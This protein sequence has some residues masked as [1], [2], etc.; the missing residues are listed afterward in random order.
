MHIQRVG[1]G[2]NLSPVILFLAAVL[3]LIPCAL[4]HGETTLKE[5]VVSFGSLPA[6]WRIYPASLKVS[7]DSSRVAWVAGRE[8]KFSVVV[9]SEG[10][11]PL[12]DGIGADTP[13]FSPDSRHIAYKAGKGAK[14]MLVVDS[15]EQ[16][17]YDGVSAPLFSPDSSHWACVAQKN[18]KQFV[19]LDG[20]EGG[21]YDGIL[22]KNSPLFS[23]N[24]AHVAYVVVKGRKMS[25]VEDGREG[26]L[27]DEVS[28]PAWS[29]DSSRLTYA[30]RKAGKWFMVVNGK[31]G[32]EYERIGPCAFSPDSSHSAYTARKDD[33][34]FM[35]VDG[36][37]GQKFDVVAV[38]IYSPD[39]NHLACLA[40]DDKKWSI[41]LDGRKGDGYDEI[42]FMVFSPDSS[43]VSCSVRDG[44]KWFMVVDGKKGPEYEVPPV[45]FYSPDSSRLVYIARKG[46]KMF[47]V[48]NGK[49]GVGYERITV[50]VFSP[51]SSHLAYMALKDGKWRV[52]ADGKEGLELDGVAVP[53][54]SP[55]SSHLAY[56]ALKDEEWMVVVDGKKGKTRFAGFLKGSSLVFDSPTHLHAQVFAAF[57]VGVWLLA[58]YFPM[59]DQP[60]EQV[61]LNVGVEG[62]PLV[63]KEVVRPLSEFKN[64]HLVKQAYDY[65]CGSAAL[66]TILNHY[67][68]EKFD[69][70]Q[71]IHGLLRY[72]DRK[73]IEER[74]AFSLLD[75]KKFVNVL[76]Y[77]GAGY[78]AEIDDLRTLG[79]PCIVPI[80]IMGYHHFVVFRG[81]YK[82]HVFVADP[83]QG[84]VSFVLSRFKKVWYENVAFV[85][86]PNGSGRKGINALELAEDD[87]RI[88][89]LNT[90][91]HILFDYHQPFTTRAEH[92]VQEM[93][94]RYKYYKSR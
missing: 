32:P 69:E 3:M 82:G 61:S 47:V 10:P 37:E 38:P 89:D 94:D 11:G 54:F 57:L 8:G 13:V 74:R 58:G 45:S 73:M 6:G 51:D 25:M 59:L 36:R 4:V 90:T 63:I 22:Q 83:A 70:K 16:A 21:H 48:E 31:E 30:A 18:E 62:Q 49:P 26:K 35:V 42:E 66:A 29:P 28:Y 12:Y 79:M 91:G 23:P 15:K 27:Y 56:V 2:L 72:G 17:G 92:E 87:L 81:I 68:S 43:R 93:G 39:S 14:W 60:K 5:K 67:L 88:I 20:K 19:V 78:R 80:K 1:T 9:D 55:D 84:N 86:Y 34:W 33:K 52:V 77:R 24:S 7:R 50:P 41:V 46:N 40:V 44:K 71:I 64:D 53:V 85:V 65:S 76:G 75:M